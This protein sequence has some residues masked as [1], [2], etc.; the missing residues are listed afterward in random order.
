MNF[1]GPLPTFFERS[2]TARRSGT[3]ATASHGLKA[4][5]I[6]KNRTPVVKDKNCA[7]T[8]YADLN[9]KAVPNQEKANNDQD[10]EFLYS[11]IGR[12]QTEVDFLKKVLGK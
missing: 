11:K 6:M 5:P 1:L 7:L 4:K 8:E 12:L 9:T 3:N 2:S 10:N